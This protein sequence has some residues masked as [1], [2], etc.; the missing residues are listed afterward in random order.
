[1]DHQ[2]KDFQ[3]KRSDSIGQAF[4]GGEGVY[5]D[6]PQFDIV[7]NSEAIQKKDESESEE[8]TESI[9]S[10][11][12]FSSGITPPP[13]GD[14]PSE[15]FQLKSDNSGV[16]SGALP[17]SLQ[18]NMEAMSGIGLN[19]VK[20]HTNSSKPEQ[21]GAQA[22]AQGNDIHLGPG[23]E[24]HLPHEAWHVVQQKQGRVTANS[25]VK[26]QPVNDSQV[27]ETEAD[28]MGAAASSGN[29][30]T[31][32]K[33]ATGGS[34]PEAQPLQLK[35]NNKKKNRKKNKKKRNK[36]K[37]KP[38]N[39]SQTIAST[40]PPSDPED[41]WF[42][43]NTKLG[44]LASLFGGWSVAPEEDETG[45][46]F[47]PD[48]GGEKEEA[49]G[50]MIRGYEAEGEIGTPEEESGL[51]E[52]IT[53]NLVTHKREV[54]EHAEAELGL[55]VGGDGIQG[56]GE[57][58]IKYAKQGKIVKDEFFWDKESG[59]ITSKSKGEISAFVGGKG[60]MEGEANFNPLDYSASASGKASAFAGAEMEGSVNVDIMV[61]GVKSFSGKGTV[62]LTA[63]VGFEVGFHVGWSGGSLTAG[64]KGKMAAG[65][66][67]S[68]G[69]ELKIDPKS[70]LRGMYEGV[71]G[72]LGY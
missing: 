6:P 25:N 48:I 41:G 30:L 37:R 28:K 17:L 24:K 29:N 55:G 66:G 47:L 12:K 19:D 36:P 65:V 57:I 22:F 52:S 4:I 60:K 18:G 2:E 34:N 59:M 46:E 43:S 16:T 54:G 8:A 15:P 27:L 64:A 40:P 70:I 21:V 56:T 26:G 61:N 11:L 50:G 32:M 23:Q 5:V 3:T 44:K 1:M 49:V 62:G 45:T 13:P 71:K 58:E 39:K 72:W 14:P 63:G 20:V 35:G 53:V 51:I 7:S 69:Y 31:Q 67:F 10:E 9:M 68:G 38:Q 42:G 33:W